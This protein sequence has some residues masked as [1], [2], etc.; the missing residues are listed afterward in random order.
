M[1]IDKGTKRA[2]ALQARLAGLPND[3]TRRAVLE[4]MRAEANIG[5]PYEEWEPKF[6]WDRKPE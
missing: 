1:M 4:I 6:P 3:E 5:R 2:T